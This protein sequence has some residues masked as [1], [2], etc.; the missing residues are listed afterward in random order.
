MKTIVTNDLDRIR[1]EYISRDQRLASS[2]IYSPF[3]PSGLFLV[4]QRQQAILQLLRNA[5]FYPLKNRSILEVGCGS[6]GVLLEYLS[7][8]VAPERLHGTDLLQDRVVEAH[9]RLPHLPLT[10]ADGQHLPY[11]NET[12]DLVLQYTVFSSILDDDIKTK[13]AKEM[14]RVVRKTGGMIVWYD[15]WLNPT[16]PQTRGIRPPEIRQLFPDCWFEFHRVTLAP[17]IT[18]KLIRFSW[19]SCYLLEKMRL[20]NTHYLVAI[21]PN[22]KTNNQ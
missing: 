12:F 15:F 22:S 7:Y 21:R 19:L 11:P 3:N 17:P 18:R 2:D 20:L 5:D 9:A 16:N 1:Q 13:V 14:L 8:G 6:G 10:C 4:Q